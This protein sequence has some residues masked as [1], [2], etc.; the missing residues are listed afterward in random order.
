MMEDPGEFVDKDGSANGCFGSEAVGQ[1]IGKQELAKGAAESLL[2]AISGH[3]ADQE[4][5]PRIR[6]KS[7]S[8]SRAGLRGGESP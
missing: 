1:R 2:Q 3:P 7:P 6:I 4:I 8:G 5:H